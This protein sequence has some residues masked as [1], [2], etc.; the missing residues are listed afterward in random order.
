[1][2]LPIE[3][4]GQKERQKSTFR[5]VFFMAEGEEWPQPNNIIDLFAISKQARV[6]L[7]MILYK[8]I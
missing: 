5:Y 1:M 6:V 2:N 7:G 4:F 3:L 8:M